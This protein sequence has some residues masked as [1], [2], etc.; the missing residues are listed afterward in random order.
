MDLKESTAIE[1]H[2][3]APLRPIF[4]KFGVV[5]NEF[6][7]YCVLSFLGL[8]LTGRYLVETVWVRDMAHL[9]GIGVLL[10]G[11]PYGF[12]YLPISEQERAFARQA[13]ALAAD[14]AERTRQ[15]N[16]T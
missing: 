8:N 3:S 12:R 10:V 11:I 7:S 6:L 9:A 2:L 13:E 4:E 1:R 16:D 5:R 15:R 14:H